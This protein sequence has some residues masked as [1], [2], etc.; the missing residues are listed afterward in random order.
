MNDWNHQVYH[1]SSIPMF[2]PLGRMQTYSKNCREKTP[3]TLLRNM[4]CFPNTFA[5]CQLD[6]KVIG[7]SFSLFRF[8][9]WW[10]FYSVTARKSDSLFPVFSHFRLSAIFAFFPRG[11]S[12]GNP[13]NNAASRVDLKSI[14]AQL[15]L[16]GGFR[17]GQGGNTQC[18]I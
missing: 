13:M 12:D 17:F 16:R 2:F 7:W 18:F 14:E 1:V 8:F 9:P 5:I 15:W 3:S 11:Q 6:K 10:Q 4:A